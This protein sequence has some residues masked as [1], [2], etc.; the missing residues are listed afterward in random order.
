MLWRKM[1][2]SPTTSDNSLAPALSYIGN[3]TR[4]KFDAGC[5]KQVKTTF[6]HEKM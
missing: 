2:L 5:L 6:T 3:K 1:M 4:V